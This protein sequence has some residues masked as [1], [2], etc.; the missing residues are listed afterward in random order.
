MGECGCECCDCECV[1]LALLIRQP[2]GKTGE[3]AEWKTDHSVRRFVRPVLTR[4]PQVWKEQNP[5]MDPCKTS[6]PM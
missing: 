3:T 2:D 5:G 6:E 4:D 1:V